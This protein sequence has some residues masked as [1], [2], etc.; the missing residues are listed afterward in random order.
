MEENNTKEENQESKNNNINIIRNK[1]DI[2]NS[3]KEIG[4]TQYLAKLDL[5]IV[6]DEY[7]DKNKEKIENFSENINMEENEELKRLEEINESKDKKIIE[8]E[9]KIMKLEKESKNL[10]SFMKNNLSYFYMF[11][12][13]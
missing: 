1:E 12:F 3:S 13:L 2:I 10:N 7:N 6:L 8:L 5:E 9:K 11:L 4:S